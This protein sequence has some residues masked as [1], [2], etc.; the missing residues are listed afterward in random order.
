MLFLK[1]HL[2]VTVLI[3]ILRSITLK[4]M[5]VESLYI[6]VHMLHTL[7]YSLTFRGL[8]SDI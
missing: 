2:Q 3:L 4:I 7:K 6:T 8:R 5:S 1:Q